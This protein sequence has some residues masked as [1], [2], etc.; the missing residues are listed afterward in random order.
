MMV[1]ETVSRNMY[2]DDLTLAKTLDNFFIGVDKLSL[3]IDSV[4]NILSIILK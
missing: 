4:S 1:E 2:V 3:L